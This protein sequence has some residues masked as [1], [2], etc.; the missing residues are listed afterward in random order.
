VRAAFE[1]ALG[2][3]LDPFQVDALDALDEGH[4]VVVAAPTG[5]GKTVV[6]EY[7]VARALAEGRKAFYTTPLKALSNQKYGDL[8]RRHGRDAVGLLTGDNALNRD[9]PVIVMTTEVL[10]NMIYAN[11]PALDGLRY[12]ILDEVHY[13]QNAY[14]G[15]VWE[16]VI[17]HAPA[18]VDLVC[19][20]ATVSNAEE[21][22]DWLATVRGATRAVIEDRRPVQLHDLYLIGDR[23]SE[24][25]HLLPT[26]VDGHPNPEASALDAKGFRRPGARTG[27]GRLFTP[28][29][30][31]V[32]ELL[33]EDGLLPAIYFI[34]SRAA[35]DDAV[36]QCVREGRRLTTLEERR[37]IRAIAEERVRALSE[38]DLRL[39]DYPGWLAGLEAG[40]AAHH[41]GLVPP[42][43]EAV[44]ACFAVGLVKMVFATETLS[45]GINMPARSVVIEK[46]TKFTGERHDFLTPGEYTQL[47]GRAGR[48]GIDE[49]GYAI[50]LWTPWVAFDQVASLVGARSFAL[51]SSFRPTY[52]M[53]ANLVRRYPPEQAHHLLNL[54]FAQ[55]RADSDVVRLETQLERTTVALADAQAAAACELGDVEA[56]RLL[57][58]ASEESAQQ[59]PSMVAEVGAA[60][61]RTRPGDVLVV[62]G[63][64]SDGRVL[65]V[66]TT[67]RRGGEIRVRALTPQRRLLSLGPHD[68]GVPPRPVGRV[69]L[70]VPYLPRDA[71]FLRDA[72]LALAQ[73]PLDAGADLPAASRRQWRGDVATAQATA[74]AS[75]PVAGCPDAR[76]HVRAAERADRLAREAE[77]LAR[78][79][80]GRSDSLARQFDRV[81]Q[82]LESHHYVEGWAL[83]ESGQGLARLYHESDLLIMECMGDGL[84][85]GLGPADLA[86]LMSVF[87]FEARKAGDGTPWLPTAELRRRWAEIERRAGQLNI[88]EE[89]VGLPLTRVPE[90]G[91][92]TFARA[93]ARG[94]ELAAVIEDQ[95]ISGGDFVRNIKQ[96]IDLLRQVGDVASEPEVARSARQAADRLFRGVVAASSVVSSGSAATEA[97]AIP[98][99]PQLPS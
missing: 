92:V 15:P 30:P 19:L 76:A 43:K 97:R 86:G 14:R 72:A 33:G 23:N 35:C 83:S 1:A 95:E 79:V 18:E 94:D 75:H 88:V 25:F 52:N 2:F 10:R 60:L 55:Y 65:V 74:L 9:A 28:R 38:D 96:L 61:E 8:V 31:D 51:T 17:I 5:S 3:Q 54:S 40:Y 47:T 81:L 21:V 87:V 77:R 99:P 4:S 44:E 42:F 20:S 63:R 90:A 89:D 50:V 80:K 41:A 58:R 34:F 69:S 49:V 53:A 64:R 7:A 13:L 46:L 37:Q 45:L 73:A 84:F 56:Y 66:S 59:L 24:R 22:A 26:L 78:R 85:N 11:S 67:R 68:F 16:E 70:P 36:T 93:W 91:F 39:L 6:G 27:R 82:V 29:R 98:Q 48:R 62:P 12:V 32:V 71:G 57:L